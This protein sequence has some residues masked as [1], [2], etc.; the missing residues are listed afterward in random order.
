M[1]HPRAVLRQPESYP[2]SRLPPRRAAAAAP[3]RARARR[4]TG[5]SA[6]GEAPAG[7]DRTL[8]A[9]LRHAHRQQRPAERAGGARAAGPAPCI[10]IADAGAARPL[11]RPGVPHV[12]RHR[13]GPLRQG[14][15]GARAGARVDTRAADA[16]SSCPTRPGAA[17]GCCRGKARWSRCRCARRWSRPPTRRSTGRASTARCARR[18]SPRASCGSAT[19]CCRPST[20]RAWPTGTC[21][22]SA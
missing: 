11:R 21:R 14:A 13:P 12:R 6:L 3:A 5:L 20:F 19:S 17:C 1:S 8:L 9:R 15:R 22:C 7:A 10:A 18:S 4:R 2:E 16:A